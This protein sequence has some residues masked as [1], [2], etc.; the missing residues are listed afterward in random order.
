MSLSS[1]TSA[2]IGLELSNVSLLSLLLVTPA[3]KHPMV[4]SLVVACLLRSVLD[5]LPPIVEKARPDDFSQPNLS[6]RMAL[7]SFCVSDSVLLRYVTVVKA[8]FAVSFTLP[9]LWLSIVHIRPKRSA[10][11]YPRLTRR[12]VLLLCIAPFVWALPVLLVA[13]PTLIRG[14]TLWVWYQI[15][16]CYFDDN[17]FTI[18]SLVFTLVPLAL[19]VLI[20]G[21]VVLVFLRWSD[22]AQ[23]QR[24]SLCSN[25][26]VRFAALV[27]VTIVSASLYAAT[28]VRWIKEHDVLWT[29]NPAEP[30]RLLMRTSV[31]WE[32]VTPFLFFLIF[33]AQEE[34]Y[35]TWLGWL[36]RVVHIP[37]SER[38]R[39]LEDSH[40]VSQ[41]AV[42]YDSYISPI[43]QTDYSRVPHDIEA[44][45]R[46][47]ASRPA[48]PGKIVPRQTSSR[49]LRQLHYSDRRR[50]G[51]ILSILDS[52]G[53]SPPPRP[54]LSRGRTT[55]EPQRASR[56]RFPFLQNLSLSAFGS[57]PS[58]PN[59]PNS[60]YS[61]E[62][63]G[64]DGAIVTTTLESGER[65]TLE[66]SRS[67]TPMSTR[68][69]GRATTSRR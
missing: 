32:A 61:G 4:K 64:E 53:L 38:D 37:R 56:F 50:R 62:L 23:S 13:I 45:E 16:T 26:S 68:T 60:S 8:A 40:G 42:T 24:A 5:V 41:Y 39:C 6:H 3:P 10:D 69:F 48:L 19:A 57:Q 49:F 59:Q 25:R 14:Q 44:P 28:L 63:S 18:V 1:L 30:L 12:T 31:I 35:E 34:I 67:D 15:N 11:D 22:T 55:E 51:A 9:A 47:S 2:V 17:V 52:D 58:M 21:S 54:H 36:S 29:S 20:S 43:P 66:G 46:E 7:V 33:A 65:P 27:V